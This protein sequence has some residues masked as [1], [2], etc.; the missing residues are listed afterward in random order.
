[1]LSCNSGLGQKS[2]MH[3]SLKHCL[4]YFPAD[5]DVFKAQ[6][7]NQETQGAPEVKEAPGEDVEVPVDEVGGP[8][9]CLQASP[10]PPPSSPWPLWNVL[11]PMKLTPFRSYGSHFPVYLSPQDTPAT[12]TL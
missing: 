2:T 12:R 7:P 9:P 3:V 8:S 10:A 11:C 6:T 5:G 4:C 1:M